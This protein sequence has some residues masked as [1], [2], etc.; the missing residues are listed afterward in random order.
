MKKNIEE[1]YMTCHGAD[2]YG[3]F[4]TNKHSTVVSNSML[5]SES[6]RLYCIL[7]SHVLGGVEHL[8]RTHEEHI[9]FIWEMS[10]FQQMESLSTHFIYS[11]QIAWLYDTVKSPFNIEFFNTGTTPS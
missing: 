8:S 7:S 1:V 4:H 10:N 5:D 6:D 9:I 11:Y 3:A 2:T